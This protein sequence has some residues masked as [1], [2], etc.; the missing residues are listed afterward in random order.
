M[1]RSICWPLALAAFAS[2][3]LASPVWAGSVLDRIK[4]NGLITTPYGG[5]WPPYSFKNSN[6]ETDGFDVEVAREVARRLGFGIKFILN[7]DGSLI[8][9]DEQTAGHWNG[10]FDFV[11]GSMTPT[12]K[13]DEN[14]NFPV[15][16]YYALGV[17]AVHKANTTIKTPADA[18][19]KRIGA[20]KSANY[21]MYLRRQPFGIVGLP[22][23]TYKIDD[24]VVV[25][26]DEEELAFDALAKGDGVELDGVVNYLP[27]VMELI[28]KGKPF[29][30]VGLPLYRVPQSVAVEP[31]DEEFEALLKKTVD[32]MRADGTLTKLS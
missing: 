22:P 24:P 21:E 28:K 6:G 7:P 13:R 31:G 12:A 14:R 26:Y 5:E 3:A 30:V 17:L 16:Y 32:A 11:I 4:H 10:R 15:T 1:K 25:T 18:S 27:V 19:R 29:K 23:V 9:W 20:L 2:L 8:T